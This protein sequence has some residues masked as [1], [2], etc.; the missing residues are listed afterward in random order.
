MNYRPAASMFVLIGVLALS[1]VGCSQSPTPNN[2]QQATQPQPNTT[3]A[4]QTPSA[5]TPAQLP[6]NNGTAM[7]PTNGTTGMPTANGQSGDFDVL[8]GSK[9]YI[10]QQDA[11][12]DP[13]LANRFS[14]C[15]TNSDGRLTRQE[16]SQCMANQGATGQPNPASASS[17][18]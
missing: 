3:A 1:S 7:P 9:G 13:E 5:M 17:P 4:T 11:Q 2:R 10:T 8:A 12:R 16:Y 6:P 15:D 18:R 14:Q